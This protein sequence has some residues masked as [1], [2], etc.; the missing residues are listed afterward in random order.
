MPLAQK[1]GAV[2]KFAGIRQNT[3]AICTQIADGPGLPPVRQDARLVVDVTPTGPSGAPRFGP[4][5]CWYR[6]PPA[7]C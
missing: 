2:C 3:K 5:R 4:W 6:S 7:R 1:L